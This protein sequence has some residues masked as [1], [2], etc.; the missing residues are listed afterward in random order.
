MESL[1]KDCDMLVRFLN[2]ES[3][4]VNIMEDI[5]DIIISTNI[6]YEPGFDKICL[7]VDR[8]KESFKASS[9][10]DQYEYVLQVCRDQNF[11]LYITNPCFEF[12]LLLHFDEVFCL[13][14]EMLLENPRVTAKRKYT[15]QELRNLLP[16][17]SKGKYNADIL[18]GKIEKAIINAEQFCQDNILLR[19]ELGSSVGLLIKE[20][21]DY[22]EKEKEN[23]FT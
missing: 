8:D 20:L 16:G 9:N 4:I 5:S 18:S 10:N 22:E 19:N 23:L 21:K 2:R 17:Y 11:G 3:N 12:W 6:T 7:I 14:R 13:D 1:E 15:E